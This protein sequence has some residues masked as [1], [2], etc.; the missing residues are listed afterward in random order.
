MGTCSTGPVCPPDV[1]TAVDHL[2]CME[3]IDKANFEDLPELPSSIVPPEAPSLKD[4][5][6][7][8]VDG[9]GAFDVFM[10]AGSAQLQT[11]YDAGRIKGKEYAEAFISMTQLMM[12]QANGFVLKRFESEMAAI[13][14]NSQ[15]IESAYKAIT[16]ENQ[17]NKTI[18]DAYLTAVQACELPLNGAQDRILKAEQAKAQAKTVDLYDRQIDGFDEK[19]S[20]GI[21]KIIMDAWAAQGIEITST[22]A[23]SVMDS[24]QNHGQLNARITKMMNDSGITT[25]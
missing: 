21:F 14:F 18:A 17:A 24:L 20:E 19:N 11:Q 7:E 2:E 15:Y 6:T 8:L 3:K 4:V 22:Q 1:A 13:M 12:E 9:T 23:D 25:T 10:R 5:T 16:A